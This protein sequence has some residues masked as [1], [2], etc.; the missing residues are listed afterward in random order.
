MFLTAFVHFYVQI[1][2]CYFG[3]GLVWK[4]YCPTYLLCV[5]HEVGIL[6]FTTS[7]FFICLSQDVD[8][9]G[10]IFHNATLRE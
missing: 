2:M 6:Y 9:E 3:V 8:A 1:S 5:E 7:T 10:S 4:I